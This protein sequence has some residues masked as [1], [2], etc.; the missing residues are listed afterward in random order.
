MTNEQEIQ[1]E[2]NTDD[3][4]KQV[5]L[6]LQATCIMKNTDDKHK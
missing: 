2:V 4:Q 6:I 5:I 1:S 3:N